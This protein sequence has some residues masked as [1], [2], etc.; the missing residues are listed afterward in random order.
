M[1]ETRA[2]TRTALLQ[3][4]AVHVVLFALMFAGLNWTRSAVPEAAQGEVI[5]ADLVDPSALSSAG[6]N[7]TSSS[8]QTSGRSARTSA[9]SARCG[10]S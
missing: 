3:A 10:A 2:D 1:K 8:S 7:A 6:W 4:L 9:C 5:E